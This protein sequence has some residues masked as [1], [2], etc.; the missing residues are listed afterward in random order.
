MTFVAVYESNATPNP[1][2]GEIVE[3]GDSRHPVLWL[4]LLLV[5]AVGLAG[6]AVYRKNER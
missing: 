3:T 4:A 1:G 5:C 2:D 6:A